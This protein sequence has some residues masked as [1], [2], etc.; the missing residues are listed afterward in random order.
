MHCFTG[1]WGFG[2]TVS[3]PL[4]LISMWSLYEEALHLIF[5]TFSEGNGTYVAVD[6]VC[7]WKVSSE[8]SYMSSCG[9]PR[10][11]F[12]TNPLIKHDS[13]S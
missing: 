5:R 7:L 3:L 13:R 8:F 4:L 6:L 12:L 11:Y 2:E 9:N 10:I 1:Q